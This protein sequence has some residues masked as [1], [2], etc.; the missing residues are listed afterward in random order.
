M[1]SWVTIAQFENPLEAHVIKCLLVSENISVFFVGE[2]FSAI[3]YRYT[4]ALGNARLKVPVNLAADA[5]NVLLNYHQGYYQQ[6]LEAEFELAPIA[7][8]QCG[9]AEIKE[10]SARPSLLFGALIEAWL[11]S[12]VFP[13]VKYK[14]C[15]Q[16]KTKIKED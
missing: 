3:Q 9:S 12:L 14:I 16:C 7:C 6:V 10:V 1:S 8:A 13:P 11:F 15:K 2:Y 5:K 4:Y